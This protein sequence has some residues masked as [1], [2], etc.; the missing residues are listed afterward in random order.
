MSNEGW[1]HHA[2]AVAPHQE[3]AVVQDGT[4]RPAASLQDGRLQDVPLVGLGVVALHQHHVQVGEACQRGR[5]RKRCEQTMVCTDVGVLQAPVCS[6]KRYRI[7]PPG[8]NV[9]SRYKKICLF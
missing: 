5:S 4:A 3:D 6:L 1:P 2:P 9:V 8:V 7:I